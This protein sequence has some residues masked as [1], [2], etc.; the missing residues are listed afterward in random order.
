MANLS[1]G[2]FLASPLRLLRK[3]ASDTEPNALLSPNRDTQLFGAKLKEG[4][5]SLVEGYCV[6]LLHT[7]DNMI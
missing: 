4:P 3:K 7:L 6:V 1:G 5:A 2:N